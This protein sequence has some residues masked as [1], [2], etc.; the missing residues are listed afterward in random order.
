MQRALLFLAV[1]AVVL[2]PGPASAGGRG[3]VGGGAPKAH[4]GSFKTGHVRPHTFASRPFRHPAP[5]V[6]PTTVDPWKFWGA[7]GA[8]RHHRFFKKPG[9]T[10]GVVFGGGLVYWPPVVYETA[11]TVVY[12]P[13][14]AAAYS[15]PAPVP[16]VIEYPAGWYELHGD[17]V[18]S[19]YQWVWIPKPPAPPPPPEAAPPPTPSP[20]PPAREGR[21]IGQI[22]RWTDEQGVTTFTDRLENVPERYRPRA[23]PRA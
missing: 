20:Q 14:P 23:E 11:E 7:K 5:S 18:T 21:T 6:F 12:T 1:A 8:H 3:F 22:Y 9:F 17:G 4:A 2:V 15:A 13:A 16:R 10:S 19:A